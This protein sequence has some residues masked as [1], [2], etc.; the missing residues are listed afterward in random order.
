MGQDVGG[1]GGSLCSVS[2]VEGNP[3]AAPHALEGLALSACG[4]YASPFCSSRCHRLNNRV[5]VIKMNSSRQF[6]ALRA[7]SPF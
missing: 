4:P 3:H 2:L 5:R 1:G 6:L 7:G